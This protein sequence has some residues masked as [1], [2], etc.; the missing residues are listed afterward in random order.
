MAQSPFESIHS[1][2]LPAQDHV[3]AIRRRVPAPN[4]RISHRFDIF[5]PRRAPRSH[6]VCS[7]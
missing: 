2:A 3:I 4:R 5:Q 6:P 7:L 1:L